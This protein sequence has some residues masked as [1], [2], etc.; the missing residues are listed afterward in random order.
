VADATTPLTQAYRAYEQLEAQLATALEQLV[1]TDGFADLLATSATNMMAA[2]RIANVTM[3]R[4]VRSTR[5]ATHQD[6]V[7]L[8]RQLARTED[9]LERL[10]QA[11]EE[12]GD[13]V[14]AL[15]P[16]RAADRPAGRRN[17]HGRR[18]SHSTPEEAD[19]QETTR[20]TL[21]EETP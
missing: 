1:A 11:V 15:N 2:T 16:P 13:R 10:L 6:V 21:P 4:M 20:D 14:D 17:G 3:D 18:G 7:E 9:K 12:L 8:A 5:L 19:R